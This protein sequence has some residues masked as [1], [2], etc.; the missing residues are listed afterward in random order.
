MVLTSAHH[1]LLH[2]LC[3]CYSHVYGR[4]M[5]LAASACPCRCQAHTCRCNSISQK[6]SQLC[7]LQPRP[8][9]RPTGEIQPTKLESTNIVQKAHA[10]MCLH[11]TALQR[12]THQPDEHTCMQCPRDSLHPSQRTAKPC[13]PCELDMEHHCAAQAP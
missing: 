6:P 7:A 4:R 3:R 2:Q 8:L 9:Y 13:S 5:V 11:V 12:K 1:Q 10:Q